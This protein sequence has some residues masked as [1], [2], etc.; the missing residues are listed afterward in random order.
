MYQ[1]QIYHYWMFCDNKLDC[2]DHG[3]ENP[4]ICHIM[5]EWKQVI[6]NDIIKYSQ[7]LKNSIVQDSCTES[8]DTIDLTCRARGL[9]GRLCPLPKDM[10]CNGK[11]ACADCRDEDPQ[12]SYNLS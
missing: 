5:E 3:D 2:I 1:H 4:E 8:P 7:I 6:T 10:F 11:C 9:R 12:R